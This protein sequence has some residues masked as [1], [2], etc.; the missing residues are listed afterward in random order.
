M[1]DEIE[2]FELPS[3]TKLDNT[4]P[5]KN[6]EERFSPSIPSMEDYFLAIVE[7]VSFIVIQRMKVEL[8]ASLVYQA[9]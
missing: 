7:F 8:W 3:S 4:K 9:R 1:S 5:Q 6:F 2:N